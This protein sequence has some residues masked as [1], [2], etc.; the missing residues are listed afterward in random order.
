MEILLE[1]QLHL[2]AELYQPF[3]HVDRQFNL[4]FVSDLYKKV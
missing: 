4:V 1:I 2:R 3:N